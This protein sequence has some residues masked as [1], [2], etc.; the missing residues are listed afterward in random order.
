[1]SANGGLCPDNVGV[2][3]CF[4][5]LKNSRTNAVKALIP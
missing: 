2:M 3:A 1:M 4:L 5:Q